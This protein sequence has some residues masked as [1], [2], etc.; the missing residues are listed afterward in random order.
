MADCQ[1]DDKLLSTDVVR[2]LE[3]DTADRNWSTLVKYRFLN[4]HH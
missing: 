2:A 4:G 3:L 1:N